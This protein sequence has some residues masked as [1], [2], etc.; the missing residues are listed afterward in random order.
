VAQ[1][2]AKGMHVFV[3]LLAT[4][5]GK[6]TGCAVPTRPW[7]KEMADQRSPAFWTSVAKTFAANPLVVFDLFNEPHDIS[8]DVWLR[9]GSVTYPT[10]SAAGLPTTGSYTA[11]GMQKLYDTIRATGATN[12]VSVSGPRWAT[13][14]RVM[15]STPLDGYG[16][17]VGAHTYCASCAP[18]KPQLNASIDTYNDPVIARFPF[19]LTEAGWRSPPD[20]RYNRAVIDWAGGNGVG[21]LIYAFYFPGD[22]SVVRSW[23]ETFDAGGVLTK[24]PNLSGRPVWNDFTA[25]R[26]AR[27]YAANNLPEA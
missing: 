23:D 24:E 22:Y 1:L 18:W 26:T 6:A 21:Y 10:R 27:G 9:G 11:V 19:V 5:R 4:E 3:S 20:P 14:P 8:A 13:D 16:I 7:L 2:T 12:L 15:L 17:V 25:T